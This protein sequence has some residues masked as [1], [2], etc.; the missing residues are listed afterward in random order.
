[1][2]KPGAG[3]QRRRRPAKP[4]GPR[5]VVARG[6]RRSR[7]DAEA[8]N[9]SVAEALLA[10][11]E[12]AGLAADGYDLDEL[13]ASVDALDEE[14]SDGRV[15]TA[16]D[17][18]IITEGGHRSWSPETQRGVPVAD[19]VAPVMGM[20]EAAALRVAGAASVTPMD[21]MKAEVDA[22]A[23]QE[24][25]HSVGQLFDWMV[26]M[27]RQAMEAAGP[28][29]AAAM[30]AMMAGHPAPPGMAMPVAAMQ[31]AAMNG[32]PHQAQMLHA[33]MASGGFAPHG[34]PPELYQRMMHEMAA[35]QQQHPMALM[36]KMMHSGA[37][38]GALPMFGGAK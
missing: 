10:L 38:P 21:S 20:G 32:H 6:P 25:A 17:E 8:D 14:G 36:Q 13:E 30:A 34:M 31:M 2:K 3:T 11:G 1:M 22:V 19:P 23:Q 16:S 26:R 18:Q 35:S 7:A 9:K 24:M 12:L 37:M 4:A 5:L 33:M 28:H 27:Q 29:H 15:P